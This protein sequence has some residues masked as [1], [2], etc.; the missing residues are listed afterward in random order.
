VDGVSSEGT[1]GGAEGVVDAIAS[2]LAL[3]AKTTPTPVRPMAAAVTAT[4]GPA[5]PRPDP[6]NRLPDPVNVYVMT[7]YPGIEPTELVR[8]NMN[9]ELEVS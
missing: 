5:V 4:A 7:K 6:P 2:A 9:C 1:P 3:E 8:V